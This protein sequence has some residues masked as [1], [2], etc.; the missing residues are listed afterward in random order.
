MNV[1][2][3]ASRLKPSE[4][5]ARRGRACDAWAA[6]GNSLTKYDKSLEGTFPIYGSHA[7]GA[8]LWDVDGKRYIDYMLGY[9]TVVLGHADPRVTD[10]VVREIQTG[11]N[12]SPLWRPLQV[13]VAELLTSLIPGAEMAFL[14]KTGSDATSGAL[15]LARVHTGRNKVVRWGYNGWHDWC[16][17]N[18][19]GIPESVQTESLTFRYNDTASLRAVFEEH[20]EQIACVLMM[21][22]EVEP[23]QPGFL[24]EV[25][26]IA[27][28]HGALFILDEMRSGFRMALGGAQEYFGVQA[29]LATY[30]KSFSNG[31]AISAVTGRADVLRG[32]SRTQM[33]STFYG[34]SAEMAAVVATVSALKE[35]DAIP[36]IWRM[37]TAFLQGLRDLIAEYG[38]PVEAVGY[39]PY[40]F[41]RFTA[42]DERER[43]ADKAVF[44]TETTGG[45]VLLHPGHHW[46]VSAAHVEED[47]AHT[48][49]VCRKGFEAMQRRS[50]SR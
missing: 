29:D 6:A 44:Y 1:P 25:K 31:Y 8:Y 18:S 36:H 21:P 2:T 4:E 7:R 38:V 27:H 49:D 34:N 47:I 19:Q 35:S 32:I 33:V 9:G 10:A 23:P 14:M 16:A 26:D 40:P 42:P 37:G 12:L 20:P 46:Y 39:P 41:L 13:E 30:G 28:E 22:F 24:Q 17:Q 48:L 15:R 5:W 3:P 45:G 50:V 11:S 43:E